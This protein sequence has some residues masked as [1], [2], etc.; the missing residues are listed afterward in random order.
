MNLKFLVPLDGTGTDET[1]IAEASRL[2][3]AKDEIHLIHVIPSFSPPPG[4]PQGRLLSLPEEGKAYLKQARTKIPTGHGSDLVRSGD[5]VDRILQAALE[6]NVNW[7]VMCTRAARRTTRWLLGSVAEQIVLKSSLPVVLVRPDAA[8]PKSLRRILVPVDGPGSARIVLDALKA[9][10][11]QT[12]AELALLHVDPDP[13]DPSFIA[14]AHPV[15]MKT[16][17]PQWRLDQS[18][19]ELRREGLAAKALSAGGREFRGILE[20]AKAVDADLIA[21]GTRNFGGLQEMLS[22]SVAGK[23]LQECERSLLLIKVDKFPGA[24]EGGRKP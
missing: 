22:G 19:E 24:H 8:P 11:R 9:V 13:K 21:M 10:A 14:D 1:A 15:A 7:I 6:L 12:G 4:L 16:T 23:V 18:V 17:D 5:P 2:A 3:G 20:Q